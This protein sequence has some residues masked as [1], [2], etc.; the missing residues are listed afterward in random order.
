MAFNSKLVA[1]WLHKNPDK[2]AQIGASYIISSFA[3]YDYFV[4]LFG[5]T[6]IIDVC[7]IVSTICFLIDSNLAIEH[8]LAIDYE[9][10]NL[11]TIHDFI[12]TYCEL[13]GKK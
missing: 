1:D 4:T 10:A 5:C 3:N 11:S 13:L 9:S 7:K 8:H 2:S 12:V 6:D